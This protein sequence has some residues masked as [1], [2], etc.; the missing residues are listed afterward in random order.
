MGS[1]NHLQHI[2]AVAMALLWVFVSSACGSGHPSEADGRR[3]LEARSKSEG[4]LYKINSFRKT[5]GQAAEVMGVKMYGFE[6]EAEVECLKQS[7]SA[8]ITP[9]P[10]PDAMFGDAVHCSTV[11]EVKKL[12]GT[13]RFE[14]TENGWRAN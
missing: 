2:A 1:D 9:F 13:I 10:P 7:W 4:D 12:K 14:Q 11:G 8:Q 3:V 5:N 6:Y